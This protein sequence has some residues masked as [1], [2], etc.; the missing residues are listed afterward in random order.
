M[1]KPLLSVL[2]CGAL[3]F[4]CGRSVD[5]NE[6]VENALK[7]ANSQNVAVDVHNEAKI[8]HLKGTVGTINE[9]MGAEKMANAAVGT[10]ALV[11]NG[12]TV[13]GLN[14]EPTAAMPANPVPTTIAHLSPQRETAMPAGK[15]NVTCP[16]ALSPTIRPATA[17]EAPSSRANSG[18]T[19]LAEASPM[20]YPKTELPTLN[21]AW[22]E[23]VW[24][25]MSAAT[26]V[27]PMAG[28]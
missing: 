26:C 18:A 7:Q 16:I 22:V 10:N 21:G 8:V 14:A 20:P 3:A 5:T 13:E 11:L 12:L 15:S 28:S 2:L 9:P 1:P 19:A 4:A 24:H 23:K 6:N 27:S 25:P 17:T